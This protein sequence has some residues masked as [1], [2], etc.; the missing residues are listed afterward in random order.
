ME[1]KIYFPLEESYANVIQGRRWI[2]KLLL[3]SL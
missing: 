2:F 3:L 1:F